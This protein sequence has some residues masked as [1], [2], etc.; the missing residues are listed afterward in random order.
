MFGLVQFVWS[1]VRLAVAVGRYLTAKLDALLGD[2]PTDVVHGVGDTDEGHPTKTFAFGSV[3]MA[4][5]YLGE[6]PPVPSL[7]VDVSTFHPLWWNSVTTSGLS[8][9][10]GGGASFGATS[11]GA[12]TTTFVWR[13]PWEE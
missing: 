13:V 12:S 11:T 6:N 8:D 3:P 7:P 10:T 9:N 2:N 4:W 5:I 1:G